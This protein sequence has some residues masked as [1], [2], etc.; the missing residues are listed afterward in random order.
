MASLGPWFVCC[1]A[2]PETLQPFTKGYMRLCWCFLLHRVLSLAIALG[3]VVHR[4]ELHPWWPSLRLW[5]RARWLVR[6]FNKQLDRKGQS[7]PSSGT[8]KY[9]SPA[10]PRFD[11]AKG[12]TAGRARGR[13]AGKAA[14]KMPVSQQREFGAWNC[15]QTQPKA[16]AVSQNN[17]NSF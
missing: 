1:Q 16:E 14:Q 6:D 11:Q 12:T 10:L 9:S 2:Y 7:Q 15:G 4:Q 8:D 3:A 13:K 5:K 17:E